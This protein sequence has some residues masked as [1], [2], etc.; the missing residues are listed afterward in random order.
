MT[1]NLARE[2]NSSISQ[3]T[4]RVTEL[5]TK[6]EIF[7]PTLSAQV[8]GLV[9]LENR[10]TRMEEWIKNLS[11]D[12]HEHQAELQSQFDKRETAFRWAVG[13]AIAIA[14]L[15]ITLGLAVAPHLHWK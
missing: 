10:V 7:S 5:A 14:G 6:M 11:D 3:L 2:L 12:L 13:T 8:A 4:E 15:A 9:S 1:D